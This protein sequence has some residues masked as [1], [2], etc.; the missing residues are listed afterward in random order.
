MDREAGFSLVEAT[1]AAVVLAVG[2]LGVAASGVA[3]RRLAILGG[4]TAAGAAAAASV[5]AQLGA[6]PCAA[7]AAEA[8]PTP[9]QASVSVGAT[10][11]ARA[12]EVTLTFP[13]GRAIRTLRFAGS[14]LCDSL[15]P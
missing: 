10:G 2:V 1:V 3:A 12:F 7:P 15:L 8:V 13:D 14:L 6:R 11:A 5:A 4:R 9:Y